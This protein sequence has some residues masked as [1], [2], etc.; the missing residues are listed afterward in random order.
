MLVDDP[1]RDHPRS[2]RRQHLELAQRQAQRPVAG[3]RLTTAG[4]DRIDLA[5][6]NTG[7]YERATGEEVCAYF[8]EAAAWLTQTGRVRVLTGHE[9]LGGG[10]NG[11]QVRDLRTGELHDVAVRRKVVDARYLEASIPAT[12]VV[13]FDVAP[14]VRVA[15][16][17]RRGR[18]PDSLDPAAGCVVL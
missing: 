9:H 5:G 18:R 8:T 7:F 16:G 2:P 11:E 6:E 14:G 17:Q 13:P 15:S 4:A 3:T 12:H 1:Y 10:S